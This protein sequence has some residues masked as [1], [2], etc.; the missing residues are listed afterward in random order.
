MADFPVPATTTPL[1]LNTAL[2]VMNGQL[3]G[4]V[5]LA[6]PGSLAWGA[7][8]TAL[9]TP[10]SLSYPYL[11]NRAFWCN[12]SAVVSNMEIGIYSA[13]GAKLYSSG[14]VVQAGASALQYVT[15]ATPLLLAPGRYYLALTCSG[16]TNAIL[17]WTAVTANLGRML[18]LYQQAVAP[19]SLPAAWTPASWALI[20]LPI[21]GL[22]RTTTGF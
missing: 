9:Y 18:G 5:A 6:N 21:M 8:N 12:G 17:G 3:R 14:T 13:G 16:T 10:F 4:A 15:L 2:A 7:A 11:V 20:G 1:L 22:T 19:G